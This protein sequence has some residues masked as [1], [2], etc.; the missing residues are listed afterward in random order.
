MEEED[1]EAQA[2]ISKPLSVVSLPPKKKVAFASTSSTTAPSQKAR[3]FAEEG[4]VPQGMVLGKASARKS[5]KKDKKRKEKVDREGMEIEDDGSAPAVAAASS[6][7]I[8]VPPVGAPYD[9]K[10]FFRSTPQVS[11]GGGLDEDEEL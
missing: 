5:A 1:D 10:A 4:G 11:A 3:L 9:F 6:S 7:G 8:A 2:A